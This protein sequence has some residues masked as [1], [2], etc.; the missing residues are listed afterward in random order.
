MYLDKPN[1]DIEFMAEES[2]TIKYVAGEMQGWRL[3]MEDAH[4]SNLDFA[5]GKVLFS[6]FDGHGGKEVAHYS[7]SHFEDVL[8]NN[9]EFTYENHKEGLRQSFLELDN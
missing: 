5:N 9:K 1:T 2:K 7:K 6:V 4:I 3:N 8:R